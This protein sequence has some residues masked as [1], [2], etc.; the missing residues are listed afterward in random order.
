M[1]F[2]AIPFK[3]VTRRSSPK[4]KRHHVHA[5]PEKAQFE[6]ALPRVDGYQQAIRNRISVL[7][8]RLPPVSIDSDEDPRRSADKGRAS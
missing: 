8:S 6:I 1:S 2:E 5:L 7:W 4:P 3:Q